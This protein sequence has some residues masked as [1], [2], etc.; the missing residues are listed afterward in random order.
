VAHLGGIVVDDLPDR[1]LV[2]ARSPD[3]AV[4][5]DGAED[6]AA[7]DLGHRQPLVN[8]LLDQHLQRNRAHLLAL[9]YQI[10]QGLARVQPADGLH[11]EVA[12][13][14]SPQ[15]KSTPSKA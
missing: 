13:L 8:S 6:A 5:A 7:R 2:Q 15:A 3:F 11:I 12:E 10:D 1:R 4:F 9:P 14:G